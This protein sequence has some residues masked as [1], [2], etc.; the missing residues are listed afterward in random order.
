MKGYYFQ[1]AILLSIKN[2]K[3]VM[4]IYCPFV[5]L[6]YITNVW[7]FTLTEVNEPKVPKV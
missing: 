5:L 7:G 2:A 3:N 6:Y 1:I 4:L